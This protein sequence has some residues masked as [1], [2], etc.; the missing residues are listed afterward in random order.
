MMR[1]ASVLVLPSRVETF[2]AVVAEALVSGL[3]VVSTSVGAIPELVDERSGRLVPPNDPAALADALDDMLEGLGTFDA[4][5]IA[6]AA[7]GRYSL[8]VV[9]GRLAGIYEAV[10]AEAAVGAPAP[11]AASL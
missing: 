7:S 1:E 9:G 8:E 3:P 10:V 2:G 6:E 5:A 4:R 11:R